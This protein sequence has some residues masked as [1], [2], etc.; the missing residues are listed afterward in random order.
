[1][2]KIHKRI[3]QLWNITVAHLDAFQLRLYIRYKN[4]IEEQ[5]Y[6]QYLDER[7]GA[8]EWEDLK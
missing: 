1:M 3:L 2:L 5:E 4:W 8:E 7:E 6:I